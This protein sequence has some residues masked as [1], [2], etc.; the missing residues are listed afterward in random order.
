LKF[1]E[2]I[3]FDTRPFDFGP[4]NSISGQL[5][6]YYQNRKINASKISPV[7]LPAPCSYKLMKNY[8]PNKISIIKKVCKIYKYK[9]KSQVNLMQIIYI[10]F[11]K[12][13]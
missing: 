1:D 12:L 9:K 11:Q 4:L 6:F 7:N 13:I 2:I 8:Y 3:F 5:A 10:I